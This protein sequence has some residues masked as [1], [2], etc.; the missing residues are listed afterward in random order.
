MPNESLNLNTYSF[1]PVC[2]HGRSNMKRRKRKGRIKATSSSSSQEKKEG[3]DEQQKE[4][5]FAIRGNVEN[6]EHTP[7]QSPPS[8]SIFRRDS[9]ERERE[10]NRGKKTR[11]RHRSTPRDRTS[12]HHPWIATDGSASNERSM[13]RRLICRCSSLLPCGIDL[14]TDYLFSAT[15]SS[16]AA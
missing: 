9:E 4:A 11:T 10:S 12:M 14:N 1:E 3:E 15:F 6:S 7:R 13:L 8:K 2:M 5:A 16:Q